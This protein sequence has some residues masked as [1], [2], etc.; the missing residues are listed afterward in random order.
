MHDQ[1]R[2]IKARNDIKS[3]SNSRKL[4]LSFCRR[5]EEA[6]N[7]ET[8]HQINSKNIYSTRPSQTA[9]EVC[10]CG[11]QSRWEWVQP[12]PTR[13]KHAASYIPN[14]AGEEGGVRGGEEREER[15]RTGDRCMAGTGEGKS[16]R[17]GGTDREIFL[18][19]VPFFA[20]AAINLQ[21]KHSA[22][23]NKANIMSDCNHAVVSAGLLS[24]FYTNSSSL[25]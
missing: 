8:M 20:V 24:C 18:F 17:R 5:R 15:G 4:C 12:C 1:F 21:S 10:S 23:G 16:E 3:T 7:H 13:T 9:Q 11:F 6:L 22:K 19:S 2:K 14:R 25:T